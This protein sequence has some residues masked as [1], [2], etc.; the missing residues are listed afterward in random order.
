MAETI[1]KE[2]LASL[3]GKLI[4]R[5]PVE[6]D[7]IST[8]CDGTKTITINTDKDGKTDTT[9]YVFP[10]SYLDGS[11]DTNSKPVV[12]HVLSEHGMIT[13]YHRQWML[14]KDRA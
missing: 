11:D 5:Q 3:L 6:D 4:N 8:N 7:L 1:T 14:G 13:D 2:H 12:E 10:F 9:R